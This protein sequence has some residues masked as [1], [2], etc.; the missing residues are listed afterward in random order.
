MIC[1]DFLAGL[2][3]LVDLCVVVQALDAV[4][5]RVQ[6]D[7]VV[8]LQSNRPIFQSTFRLTSYSIY[9]YNGTSGADGKYEIMDTKT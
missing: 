2:P 1:V 6:P 5:Q 3:Q 9:L 7:D 4:R 8:V